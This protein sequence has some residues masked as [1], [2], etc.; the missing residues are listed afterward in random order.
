MSAAPLWCGAFFVREHEFHLLRHLNGSFSAP[1]A[2]IARKYTKYSLRIPPHRAK[3]FLVHLAA[4]VKS[5]LPC[6]A[7]IYFAVKR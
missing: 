6:C 2:G 3:K 7:V 1:Y 5:V 4:S